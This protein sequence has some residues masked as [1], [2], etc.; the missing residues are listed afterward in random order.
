MFVLE[1]TILVLFALA[2]SLASLWRE[3]RKRQR[4]RRFKHWL[5]RTLS[6]VDSFPQAEERFGFPSEVFEGTSGRRLYVWR[7]KMRDGELTVTL[8]AEEDGRISDRSWK[9]AQTR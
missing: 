1:T 3:W 9:K 7:R 4:H 2:L 6:S 5:E 8:T